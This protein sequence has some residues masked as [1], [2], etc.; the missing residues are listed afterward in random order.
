MKISLSVAALGAILIASTAEAVRVCRTGWEDG[1]TCGY[2]CQNGDRIDGEWCRNFKSALARNGANC[3]GDC[4][5]SNGFQ[6]WC[7]KSSL[8]PRECNT[9]WWST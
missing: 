3:W 7:T 2:N 4:N 1:N 5:A 6:F 9:H 8:S